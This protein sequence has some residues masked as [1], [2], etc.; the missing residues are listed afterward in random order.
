[1]ASPPAKKG[2]FYKAAYLVNYR[3]PPRIKEYEDLSEIERMV[4]YD[5][6]FATSLRSKPKLGN[7]V[8]NHQK[9]FFHQQKSVEKWAWENTEESVRSYILDGLLNK[10]RVA[11]MQKERLRENIAFISTKAERIMALKACNDQ[12]IL[13]W[14]L[15]EA[16]CCFDNRIGKLHL[17]VG[18]EYHDNPVLV[19]EPREKRLSFPTE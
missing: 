12:L 7:P 13:A 9:V 5:I 8:V 10:G 2:P 4:E 11:I 14:R 17:K 6:A 19:Y 1:M 3:L 18:L 15:L 16:F